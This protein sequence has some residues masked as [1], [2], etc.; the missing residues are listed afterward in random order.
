M[1]VPNKNKSLLEIHEYKSTR[2]GILSKR[3]KF[4]GV[5]PCHEH[6][7][8]LKVVF[9]RIFGGIFHQNFTTFQI[10]KKFLPVQNESESVEV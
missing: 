10:F 4:T 3:R 8:F 9:Q 7:Q 5:N 2:S 1:C 6:S